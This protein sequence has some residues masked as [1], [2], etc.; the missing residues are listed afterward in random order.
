M[1]R[2]PKRVAHYVEAGRLRFNTWQRQLRV[3]AAVSDKSD[4]E[5]IEEFIAKHGVRHVPRG[6]SGLSNSS[7]EIPDF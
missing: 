2:K 5:L 4:A 1:A 6:V 7:S 3:V